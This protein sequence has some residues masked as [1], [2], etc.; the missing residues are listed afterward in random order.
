MKSILIPL[1][2]AG[3]LPVAAT[4]RAQSWSSL[5]GS[6]LSFATTFEGVG[7]TGTFRQ[8]DARVTFNPAQPQ[9][10][11]LEASIALASATTNNPDRDKML[12]TA[13]FFDVAHFPNATYRGDRC[14][15]AGNG[16]Y[17][18]QG[19]L[20]LR[21][22]ARPVPLTLAWVQR[23]TGAMLTLTATVPRLAFGVG[24]GQWA[25]PSAIGVNVAVHGVIKLTPLR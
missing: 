19:T 25:D 12:P 8:F 17:T 21:G 18:A 5:P 16:R 6:N 10:C 7:F 3:A 11:R 23:G 24:T 14:E 4:V 9:A 2:L 22:V 1:M 13:A 20:T 15:P